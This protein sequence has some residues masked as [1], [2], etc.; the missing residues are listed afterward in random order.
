VTGR[1]EWHVAFDAYQPSLRKEGRFWQFPNEA[2][3]AYFFHADGCEYYVTIDGK[4]D[5]EAREASGGRVEIYGG[6]TGNTAV[7]VPAGVHTL[8][9]AVERTNGAGPG[10]CTLTNGYFETYEK[11]L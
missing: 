11:L 1:E 7:A 5:N 6:F 4:T 10:K 3:G 8:G 9:L 2:V